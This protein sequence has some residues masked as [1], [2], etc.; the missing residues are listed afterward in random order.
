MGRDGDTA[1]FAL[2]SP[3]KAAASM[4]FTV[5]WNDCSGG[6]FSGRISQSSKVAVA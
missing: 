2:Y 1:H 6:P 5:A 4:P 3:E